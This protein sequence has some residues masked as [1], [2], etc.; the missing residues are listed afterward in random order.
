MSS[1]S[2]YY[3]WQ[4]RKSCNRSK[5]IRHFGVPW[6]SYTR[7]IPHQS[8]TVSATCSNRNSSESSLGGRYHLHSYRRK[9]NLSGHHQRFCILARL[10]LM[11]FPVTFDIAL[12]Q[13]ALDSHQQQQEHESHFEVI[14][15]VPY[16]LFKQAICCFLNHAALFLS[17]RYLCQEKRPLLSHYHLC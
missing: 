4:E 1:R 6:L 8:Q 13:K 10:Q 17:N 7:N 9:L 14:E 16:S 5:A 15:Y 2:G 3:D 11:P 12:S